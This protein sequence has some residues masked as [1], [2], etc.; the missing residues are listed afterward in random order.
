MENSKLVQKHEFADY[1][2]WNLALQDGPN[3][4]WIATRDLSKGKVSSYLPLPIQEALAD[5]FFRECDVIETSLEIE[6]NQIISQVKISIL[7]DYPHAEH[8]TI[9]GIGAR[10][11]TKAG[12]SLEYGCRSA[13]NAA[14]SEAFTDFANIFGRN[15][16]REFSNDFSF[17]KSKETKKRLEKE[18][19]A[20]EKESQKKSK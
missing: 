13:K 4:K 20:E 18:K 10:V 12:N 15:L 14:K 7:P 2:A 17:V 9:S 19:E 6:N 3:E 8:R 11:M 1:T 5:L 16:N